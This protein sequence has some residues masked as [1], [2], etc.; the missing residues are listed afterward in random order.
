MRK[1][2]ISTMFEEDFESVERKLEDMKV[3]IEEEKYDLLYHRYDIY[4]K[5]NI[6]QLAQLY[7][8]KKHHA[9]N[10]MLGS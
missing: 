10:L 4:A 6:K 1:V 2:I 5:V 9:I 8:F 7:R 3:N